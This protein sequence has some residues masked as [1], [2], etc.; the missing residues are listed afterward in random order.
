MHWRK[1][2]P[3]PCHVCGRDFDKESKLKKHYR[4]AHNMEYVKPKEA[5]HESAR[6]N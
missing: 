5:V 2:K 6:E 3:F 4:D 1:P